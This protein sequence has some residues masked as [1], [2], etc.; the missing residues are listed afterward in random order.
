MHHGIN[1]EYVNGMFIAFGDSGTLATSE[2]GVNWNLV[3]EG[4]S[5][6]GLIDVFSWGNTFV[7]TNN[8][9]NMGYIYSR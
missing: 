1:L 2:D 9:N 3:P 5:A 8:I 6:D 7:A 4:I